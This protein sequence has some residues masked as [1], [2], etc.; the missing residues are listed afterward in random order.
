MV[1]CRMS[2]MGRT[3]AIERNLPAQCGRCSIQSSRD[4]TKRRSTS[5][6]SRSAAK[7]RSSS[8]VSLVRLRTPR[9]RPQISDNRF[10]ILAFHVVDVHRRMQFFAFRSRTLFEDAFSLLFGETRQ[11]GKR[12]R[13]VRP[14]RNRCDGP[15]PY[16]R[17]GQPRILPQF[18]TFISRFVALRALRDF[19]DEV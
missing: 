9:Q 19:F 12:R 15:D 8:L 2:T 4:L 6:P 5:D 13:V 11:S 1:I 14:I 3:A 18:S 16:R 10:R 17:A 7:R